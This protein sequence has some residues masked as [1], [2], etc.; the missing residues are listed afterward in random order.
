M[1]PKQ[2]SQS[3]L[4][5]PATNLKVTQEF[6]RQYQQISRILD[7]NPDILN[8]VHQDLKK[9]LDAVNHKR[10]SGGRRGF[11]YTT[12]N[13]LRMIICR[14]LEGAS[15]R[16]IAVRID[17]SNFLRQFVRIYEGPMMD[18]TTLN[19][20]ECVIRP[21]TWK[22]INEVLAKWAAAHQKIG[23]E[24][25]RL[26]TTAVETNI[27]YPTDSSLLWDLYRVLARNIEAAREVA[28]V[29]V[30]T[31]RLQVDRV[32]KL[33]HQIARAAGKKKSQEAQKPLYEKLL[34]HA[35]TICEWSRELLVTLM[36]NLDQNRYGFESSLL[37]EAIVAQL[38]HFLELAPKVIDQAHRRVV[39]GEQVPNDDKLFSLFEDHTE[40]LIRGKAHKDIEFGHMVLISQVAGKF[41]TH[42]DVFDKK[43][44]KEHTLISAA[45][46]AHTAIF[47][48]LPQRL[49]ADKGFYESMDAI[50]R[51]EKKI[52]TVAIG[53]K[54]KRDA[55]ETAREHSPEFRLGQRFRAGVEGTISFLKRVFGMFRVLRKGWEH[56]AAEIGAAVFAHNLL[57]LTR[58]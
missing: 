40:L 55:A 5:F 29:A 39:L 15:Y 8:L 24:S 44:T 1:R 48:A 19:K 42:Y 37:A 18:Y 56:F 20:L 34:G 17:D 26:D 23:G 53:K 14:K 13:M 46:D 22:R 2:C 43:P 49:S 58:S 3:R 31:R 4:E 6:F 36:L 21:E 9:S 51:L 41:I 33:Q 45:L 11:H 54:G 16:D 10:P 30:G 7:H 27:H 38:A 28:P 25:L 32:K 50:R 47:N 57:I 12:E 52:E 35:N